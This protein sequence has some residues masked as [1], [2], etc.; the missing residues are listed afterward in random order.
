VQTTGTMTNFSEDEDLSYFEGTGNADRPEEEAERSD[1]Q[2]T[3]VDSEE[4][5]AH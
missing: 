3:Q 1:P 2:G 5:R 4:L